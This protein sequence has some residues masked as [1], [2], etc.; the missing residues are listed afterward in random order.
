MA[1]RG[2]AAS[3]RAKQ[4]QPHRFS[5]LR[6]KLTATWQRCRISQRSE[7]SVERLLAFRDYHRSTSTT[8]VILVCVLVP[9]PAL[10]VALA[11]DCIPL[12][13]P[14]E[15]WRANYAV[16]IRLCT[17]MF[18]EALGVVLQVREVIMTGTI[19]NIQAS[20]IAL[21]TAVTC[22]LAT[23]AVAEVWKFP[24]PF[25][26]VLMT[27]VYVIILF[28]WMILGIGPRV[29]ASSTVLRQ[30]IKAQLF[31]IANQGVVVVKGF[32]SS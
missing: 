27:N 26:Y 4:Q 1:S 15:G 10:L 24:I 19:S 28:V 31:I 16:W 21:G 29:L 32:S 5:R 2:R 9:I 14:S 3:S 12:R 20:F 30:Q 18:F 25:G 17:A 6:H 8:R 11:I 13:P 7:Y 22:V 23:I